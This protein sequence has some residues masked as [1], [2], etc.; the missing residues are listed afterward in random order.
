MPAKRSAV[1]ADAA[2]LGP[3]VPAV[4]QVGEDNA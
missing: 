2:V 3:G 1:I 4:E